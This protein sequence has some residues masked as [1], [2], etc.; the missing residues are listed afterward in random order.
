MTSKS[1]PIASAAVPPLQVI[2]E[3]V[4][5]LCQAERSGG[6][7]VFLQEGSEGIGPP[8]H[9][10]AWDE[11]YFVLE[12]VVEV[13]VGDAVHRLE[14]GGFLYVPGGTVHSY[15][16]ASAEVRMLSLTNGP[17]AAAFFAAMDREVP[18]PPDL[19]T[20][21]AVAG[22]NGVQVVAPPTP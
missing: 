22:K 3:Q 2:G 10:H 19:G 6:V 17:G 16:N 8:P 21:V 14:A 18:F 9:Q 4:R 13:S 11:A 12:G 7:E 1:I 15:R 20:A 5:V